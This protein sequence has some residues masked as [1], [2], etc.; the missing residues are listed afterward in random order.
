M[1]DGESKVVGLIHKLLFDMI[2]SSAGARAV[3]EIER[4]AGVSKDK[5]F[6]I[7]AVYDAEEWRGLLAATREVLNIPQGQAKETF[8]DSFCKDAIEDDIRERCAGAPEN[9]AGTPRPNTHPQGRTEVIPAT[10][11]G[12]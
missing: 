11:V 12:I 3:G 2:D 10:S 7:D 9:H 6:R 8:A 1:P 5:S 4:C